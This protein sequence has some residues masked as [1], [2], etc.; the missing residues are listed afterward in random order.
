MCS[1]VET[2]RSKVC[3]PSA[4]QCCVLLKEGRTHL[5]L[6]SS[7]RLQGRRRIERKFGFRTALP[8]DT[9]T[10][11]GPRRIAPGCICCR[12]CR[13][14]TASCRDARHHAERS[15]DPV[16]SGEAILRSSPRRQPLWLFPLS[17]QG[18]SVTKKVLQ[19][20]PKGGLKVPFLSRIAHCEQFSFAVGELRG[21]PWF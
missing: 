7:L 4:T 5:R 9:S 19:H 10:R 2:C 21:C 18:E 3:P 11:F 16:S 8:C 20:H 13:F 14:R 17:P 12:C 1:N 6:R 15:Q